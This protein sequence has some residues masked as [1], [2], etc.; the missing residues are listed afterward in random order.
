ME[1]GLAAKLKV[2]LMFWHSDGCQELIALTISWDPESLNSAL[3]T[4]QVTPVGVKSSGITT[5]L[6]K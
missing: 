2:L 1:S 5:R 3:P 4:G 6:S